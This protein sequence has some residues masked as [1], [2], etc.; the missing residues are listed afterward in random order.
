MI[1]VEG[2]GNPW[3]SRDAAGGTAPKVRPGEL[4]KIQRRGEGAF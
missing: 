2:P 4:V 3:K 1:S